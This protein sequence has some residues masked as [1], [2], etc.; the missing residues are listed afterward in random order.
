MSNQFTWTDEAVKQ[1][2]RVYAA[3]RQ[4]KYK[5]ARKIE[6]KMNIFKE[7]GAGSVY[8]STRKRGRPST[9]L[10]IDRGLFLDWYLDN[11]TCK[12]F[13]TIHGVKHELLKNGRFWIRVEDM[14]RWCGYLPVEVVHESMKDNVRINKDGEVDFAYYTN[15]K[16][17][18]P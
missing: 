11:D 18:A 10:L 12:D 2:A 4:G 7:V 9:T 14:V 8:S 13:V 15:Y 3:G 16:I 6:D 5:K 1:F 17:V